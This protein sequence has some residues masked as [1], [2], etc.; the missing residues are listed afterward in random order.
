MKKVEK[1]AIA[2]HSEGLYACLPEEGDGR[3]YTM[4][5]GHSFFVHDDDIEK[6]AKKYDEKAHYALANAV[7]LLDEVY[8]EV[9]KDYINTKVVYERLEKAQE[10]LKLRIK[11]EKAYAEERDSASQDLA[12]LERLILT[13]H[14]KIAHFKGQETIFNS[15]GIIEQLKCV[16]AVF[17]GQEP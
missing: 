3:L 1:A 14:E 11:F 12:Q 6:W 10:L 4:H 9:R 17:K 13:T 15:S 8:G 7:K 5:G 16:M 2:M